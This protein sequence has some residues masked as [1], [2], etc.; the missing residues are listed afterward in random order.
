MIDVQQIIYALERQARALDAWADQ[1]GSQ[2]DYSAEFP[3]EDADRMREAIEMLRNAQAQKVQIV[4]V[5]WQL[6]PKEP[7]VEMLMAAEDAY[8]SSS[9]RES[10]MYKAM[11]KEAPRPSA[12][13]DG[14]A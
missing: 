6:V 9:F 13:E 2:G 4:P 8:D 1:L 5:G 10:R 14:E 7:T 11:L 12:P 3:A